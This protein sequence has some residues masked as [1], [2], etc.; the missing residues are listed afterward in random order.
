MGAFLEKDISYWKPIFSR[1]QPLI[2]RGVLLSFE[3]EHD[4]TPWRWT[5]LCQVIYSI[6]DLFW[7]PIVGAHDSPL[8]SGHVFNHPKKVTS[9]IARW[10]ICFFLVWDNQ[11]NHRAPSP[12]KKTSL[13]TE[14]KCVF[15]CRLG[16]KILLIGSPFFRWETSVWPV[17]ASGY[18]LPFR[19]WNPIQL[20]LRKLCH[21]PLKYRLP[22]TWTMNLSG[23]TFA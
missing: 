13:Q 10:A 21:K 11:K 23:R 22:G 6:R 16:E 7:S 8:I 18:L 19:G 14:R 12:L 1:F 3:S 17:G 4:D 20:Y 2:F 15:C 9:R 5:H